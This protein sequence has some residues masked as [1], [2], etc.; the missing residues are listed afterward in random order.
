M[1]TGQMH[2][3]NFGQLEDGTIRLEQRD[4]CGE[5]TLVDMH[6]CQLRHVAESVGLLVP[7]A[8]T[9]TRWPRGFVRRMERLRGQAHDLWALLDSVPCFPPGRGPT[10]DVMA[11][12]DLLDNLDDLLADFGID[13]GDAANQATNA[14]PSDDGLG[15]GRGIAS[16]TPENPRQGPSMA[17]KELSEPSLF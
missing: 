5:P 17:G 13:C 6:P 9:T 10:D 11:A 7:A 15:E 3:L 1:K 8:T 12:G 2:D 16:T 14:G 4:Y